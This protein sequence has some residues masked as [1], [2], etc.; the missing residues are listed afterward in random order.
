[1]TTLSKVL[2]PLAVLSLTGCFDLDVPNP[3]PPPGPGTLQGTLVYSV[4]G[5]IG[6]RPAGGAT[7][8]L[9]NSSVKTVSNGETGRFLIGGITEKSGQALIT[10]DSD[11]DGTV[12]RQKVIDF[13]A[14]K[15]GPGRDVE[16]G[17]VSLGRNA[18]VS[19]KVLLGDHPGSS[20]H[21]GTTVFVASTAFLTTT[22]DDGSFLLE[23]LAEG[24]VELSIYRPGYLLESREVTLSG[25]QEARLSSVSLEASPPGDIRPST[26]S[27]VVRLDTGMPLAS[28]HVRVVLNGI[29]RAT[30]TDGEGHFNF[31]MLAPGLYQAGVE[32]SDVSSLKIAN[33]LVGPGENEL[34]VLTVTF[35]APMR[36]DLGEVDG[37]FIDNSILMAR[38]SAP[39]VFA[40]PGSQVVLN[41]I[42][43]SGV[44]PLVYHWKQ[45]ATGPQVALSPNDSSVAGT[46]RFTAPG[47]VQKLDFD[48]TVT[49]SRQQT[50]GPAHVTVLVGKKPTAL[51]TSPARLQSGQPAT[52]SASTSTSNDSQAI[53]HYRWHQTSGPPSA[54]IDT[55]D[56]ATLAITAPVVTSLTTMVLTLQVETT[57]GILSDPA[58]VTLFIDP[59]GG[60]S[61]TVKITSGS[62]VQPVTSYGSAAMSLTATITNAPSDFNLATYSWT[63]TPPCPGPGFDGGVNESCINFS[64]T[65]N[66]TTVSFPAPFN[67]GTLDYTV[68]FHANYKGNEVIRQ[69]TRFTFT[70]ASPP[71]CDLRISPIGLFYSCDRPLTG[72]G[73]LDAGF[74]DPLQVGVDGHTLL[75]RFSKPLPFNQP[76]I[77]VAL[78]GV[79]TTD[80]FAIP[81]VHGTFNVNSQGS[82]HVRSRGS[83]TQEPR[84]GF[85]SINYNTQQQ[86]IVGRKV[87][88]DGRWSLWWMQTYDPSCMTMQPCTVNDFNTLTPFSGANT[89]PVSGTT[90]FAVGPLG[91]AALSQTDPANGLF[92]YTPNSGSW[93]P[94]NNTPAFI[95]LGTDGT[96]LTLLATALP[97]LE[98]Q[99]FNSLSKTW[100]APLKVDMTNSYSPMTS[101]AM[102]DFHV[103]GQPSVVATD[104]S[105]QV[106]R[107]VNGSSGWMNDPVSANPSDKVR[108]IAL[109]DRSLVLTSQGSTQLMANSVDDVGTPF[110]QQ[111]VPAVT[112]FDVVP[113]GSTALVAYAE[114]FPSGKILLGLYDLTTHQL[115]PVPCQPGTDT[116]WNNATLPNF[117]LASF[118]R[119]TQF[120]DQLF[121]TWQETDGTQWRMA[122]RFIQ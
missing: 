80:G 120:N 72:S 104:A 96:T 45:T 63:V 59:P 27:G 15:A 102:F 110:K 22:G 89:T 115:N 77:G 54:N 37:G 2:V 41:G 119:F 47:T 101:T 84:P 40:D 105:G 116:S 24:V 78:T 76:P 83:S 11:H 113:W 26:L 100:S 32:R 23:G 62:A 97:G 18:A 86:Q 28:A 71:K 75:V 34:G 35:G 108:G 36:L 46:T 48:L 44:Q 20:G 56:S 9:M 74:S 79:K 43:S 109:R 53:A 7:V 73:V 112:G 118:P 69:D 38:V 98:A 12:D 82:P 94:I 117:L 14:V 65:P 17:E 49:D 122:G 99:T 93:A 13:E 61:V 64:G 21:S 39:V 85:L 19:G 67:T 4:P 52:F 16:L 87:E 92:E 70:N 111:L 66:G 33:I 88:S 42:D 58:T 90:V 114:P 8:Q 6:S 55:T 91:Y 107:F 50:S 31:P 57:L 25:G 29:A 68:T 95:A 30:D 121:L 81:D 3:P 103:K 106:K 1:M 5:R 51:I 10:F 60:L